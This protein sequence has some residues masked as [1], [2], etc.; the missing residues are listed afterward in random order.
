MEHSKDREMKMETMNKN[1]N[2]TSKI[3]IINIC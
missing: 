2:N 1:P 3:A